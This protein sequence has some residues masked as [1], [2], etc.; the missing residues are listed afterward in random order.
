[1]S[2]I[3]IVEDEKILME[4]YT[5]LLESQGYDLSTA[6]NGEDAYVLCKEQQFDLILLD[7]MMPVLDG[8]GFLKKTNPAKTMPHTK[9]IIMSNLSSGEALTEAL[10]LGA[11]HHVVK[12]SLGPRELIA[13]VESHLADSSPKTR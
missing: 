8:V 2:K 5:I 4:A 12:S 13:M 3:L 9:V 7:L 11:H 6:V 10:Q 1:M